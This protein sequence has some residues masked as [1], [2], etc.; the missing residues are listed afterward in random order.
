MLSGD[1]PFQQGL[2]CVQIAGP[3]LAEAQVTITSSDPVSATTPVVL[4]TEIDE[5]SAYTEANDSLWVLLLHGK[6]Q[7]VEMD[8]RGS[9]VACAEVGPTL[10]SLT[11]IAGGEVQVEDDLGDLD[12]TQ[13]LEP[14]R[15]RYKEDSVA[16]DMLMRGAEDA[17]SRATSE[18]KSITSQLLQD[19]AE[20]DQRLAERDAAVAEKL[21]G[22]VKVV[23]ESADSKISKQCLPVSGQ[24]N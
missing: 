18:M 14:G 20:R 2:V 4:V 17:A 6:R 16:K 21:A 24:Q 15:T 9:A 23:S 8:V 19:A 10:L 7:S 1:T 3:R 22:V 13:V 12:D 11:N 5:D